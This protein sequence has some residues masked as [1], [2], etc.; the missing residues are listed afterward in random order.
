MLIVEALVLILIAYE[1]FA[2]RHER[3]AKQKRAK[4]LAQKRA[5]LAG[6]VER[7]EQ[8]RRDIPVEVDTRAEH[9]DFAPWIQRVDVWS[10]QTVEALGKECPKA[11]I[12]F[13]MT[14]PPSR[15]DTLVQKPNKAGRTLHIGNQDVFD[16]YVQLVSQLAN[17][18]NIAEKAEVYF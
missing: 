11:M 2:G 6:I 3:Q 12:V 14:R 7:G 18:T 10:S 8:L 15:E 13:N 5:W 17:L 16:A 1:V 4:L 9:P